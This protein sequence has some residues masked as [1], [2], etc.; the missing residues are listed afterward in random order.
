M[1]GRQDIAHELRAIH[2]V[3]AEMR[4]LAPDGRLFGRAATNRIEAI[5]HELAT[6]QRKVCGTVSLRVL[7]LAQIAADARRDRLS[8]LQACADGEQP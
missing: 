2:A 3:L 8:Y 4:A 1:S 6:I 7:T 5:E